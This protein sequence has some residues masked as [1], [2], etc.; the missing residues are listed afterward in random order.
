[1]NTNRWFIAF[2]LLFAV[3][4]FMNAE[5]A[6]L[7]LLTVAQMVFVPVM[8][9]QLLGRKKLLN[10]AIMVGVASV[11]ILQITEKTPWDAWFALG[12][13]FYTL[14]VA[15]YG[16]GRFLRRGF[17]QIEEFMIDAAMMFLSIGGFW[18]FASITGFNTGFSP[19]ITWL[20]AIHFHYASFL[21]PIFVGLLG[22]TYKPRYYPLKGTILLAAPIL[23]AIG[24][25]FSVWLELLSVAFYIVGIYAVII[26]SFKT[27]LSSLI[28]TALIRISFSG[29]GLTIIFSLL[30]AISNSTGLFN[31]GIPFMLVFHGVTNCLAFGAVGVIGWSLAI[32]ER[33]FLPPIPISKIRGQLVVGETG[34]QPYLSKETKRGLVDEFTIYQLV[35]VPTSIQDFYL[36]TEDY[37]LFSSVRWKFWFKPLAFVYSWFS[38]RVKQLNLPYDG[39]WV[40][41]TGSIQSIDSIVDGRISPRA[42]IRK[43]GKDE[44]FV[45]LYSHH[46]EKDSAYMNIALPLPKSSMIGILRLY[47]EQ[48]KL[49]L[50]SESNDETSA[51]IYIAVG[52]HLPKL[53]LT[54]RFTVWE[55]ETGVLKAIHQ[56]KLFNI[57]FLTIHYE[58]FHKEQLPSAYCP[59]GQLEGQGL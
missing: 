38:R 1:M 11:F 41:M 29:V 12:Y 46:V 26:L 42:W 8:L 21:L 56:M 19:M 3:T 58:I 25:T 47:M 24:I 55:L 28:Q 23:T 17:S 2:V 34:I 50:S 44:V 10:I 15:C 5:P 51:G 13:L 9:I 39:K 31:V 37:R 40:E 36:H 27:R 20:T 7:L 43:I 14:I 49:I 4:I 35:D 16:C 59:N 53:P 48:E 18:T 32:P 45:A 52:N 6:Y 22:R 33:K 30:Y 57:P 54:E